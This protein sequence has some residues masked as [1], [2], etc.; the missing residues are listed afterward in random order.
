MT[1]QEAVLAAADGVVLHA[2][3]MH[4]A[5]QVQQGSFLRTADAV[6]VSFLWCDHCDGWGCGPR[7]G[8]PGRQQHSGKQAE[9]KLE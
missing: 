1:R 4:Q 2:S 5:S 3:Q 9:A 7:Q 6:G 8:S